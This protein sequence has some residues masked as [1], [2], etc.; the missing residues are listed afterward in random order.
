MNGEFIHI[1][2]QN[3]ELKLFAIEETIEDASQSH[4]P[5]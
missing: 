3:W 2:D 5:D 4:P 1:S